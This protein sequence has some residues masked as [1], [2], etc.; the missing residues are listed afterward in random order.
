MGEP[1]A[2]IAVF[3]ADWDADFHLKY[4]VQHGCLII[5]WGA[6]RASSDNAVESVFVSPATGTVYRTW[7]ECQKARGKKRG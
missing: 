5:S 1:D 6:K 7:G 4:G 2:G 3:K